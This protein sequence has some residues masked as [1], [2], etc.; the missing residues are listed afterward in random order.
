MNNRIT[1]AFVLS[2]FFPFVGYEVLKLEVE[3]IAKLYCLLGWILLI[4]Y[5][6]VTGYNKGSNNG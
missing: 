5:L 6:I 3:N 4:S 2:M 1:M